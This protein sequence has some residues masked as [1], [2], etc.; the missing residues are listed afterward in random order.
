MKTPWYETS[1][2][3]LVTLLSHDL[4]VDCDLYT[5]TLIGG[6]VLRYTTGDIDVQISGNTWTAHQ[7]LVDTSDDQGRAHWKVGTGVDTWQV[8]MVPRTYDPVTSTADPDLINGLPWLQA[9]MAGALDW[10]DIKIDRAFFSAWPSALSTFA[11]PVGA[12]TLFRGLMAGVDCGRSSAALTI[13]SYTALLDIN[14]PRNVFQP[15][16]R[17][18]LFDAGCTLD[19]AAYAKT[20]TVTGGDRLTLTSAMTAPLGSGTFTLGEIVMTSGQNA[21]FR[22]TVRL[23]TPGTFL[24]LAPYYFAINPGDTFTAWPGCD[25]SQATCVLFG[26]QA[27]FG[28]QR[29]IPTSPT[30]L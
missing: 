26:N 25:K 15:S 30:A 13:Q 21:G 14:L 7:V 18:S 16:C 6:T 11:A 2:G 1:P 29:F 8:V 24:L 20:G 12:I 5:I 3:A 27:N 23:W 19:A 9:L 10:A 28:G 22:R 4:W 17:H